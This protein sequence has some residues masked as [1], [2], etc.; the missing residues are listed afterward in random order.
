MTRNQKMAMAEKRVE[1][2]YKD[3][4]TEFPNIKILGVTKEEKAIAKKVHAAMWLGALEQKSG[5]YK[6]ADEF[7]RIIII[8]NSVMVDLGIIDEHAELVRKH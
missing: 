7:I 1:N 6:E 3:L 5:K 2:I 8:G 4:K